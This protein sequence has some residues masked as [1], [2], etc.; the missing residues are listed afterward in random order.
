VPYGQPLYQQGQPYPGQ[1]YPQYP[2]PQPPWQAPGPRPRP[3]RA[4]WSRRHPAL[5]AL[6]GIVALFVL[7]G[8]ISAAAG[9]GN[10][11]APAAASSPVARQS[12]ATS[13]A[14]PAATHSAAAAQ[15]KAHTVAT[16]TGSGIEKTPQFT[17]TDT[18]KLVYSFSCADFGQSGNF[19]VF[20]DG[21]AD[22]GGVTV[23]DLALSKSSSTWAYSDGGTHYLE[24]NSECAWKVKVVDEP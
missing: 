19:Q 5:T 21:G 24:I 2:L 23:N 12:A 11:A 17:V 13:A 14:A 15:P 10:A 4:P 3:A 8:I 6:G 16:F 20:E 7:T 1:P 9:G 22:F 18:W